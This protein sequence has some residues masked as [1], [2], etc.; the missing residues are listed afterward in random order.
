MV[1]KRGAAGCR[2]Y[3]E[4]AQAVDVPGLAVPLRDTTAA[5]DCFDAAY[6]WAQLKGGSPEECA[7]LANCA[8][9]VAV[10]KLGG[11]RNVPTIEE[12]RELILRSNAQIG[13]GVE[14]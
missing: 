11:G 8:G 3:S 12:L 4:D 5:G 14:I 2:V 6:I 1:V 7:R 10:G 9:A 13:G